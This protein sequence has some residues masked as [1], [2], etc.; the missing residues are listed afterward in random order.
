MT[1]HLKIRSGSAGRATTAGRSTIL[2]LLALLLLL[3][4]CRRGFYRQQADREVNCIVDHKTQLVGVA[5]GK[6][7][8]NIDPRSRMFDPNDPDCEPMPPDDPVSHQVM[9]CVDCKRGSKCW[10]CLPKTPFVEN[11]GWLEHLPFDE[12]GQLVLDLPGA[13]ELAR[14]ESPRY[15]S[16]LEELYLS[17]LDVTFERFRFDAQ[18]FGGAEVFMTADGRDRSGTGESSSLFEVSAARPGNNLRIEKL[19]ATGGELAAGFANSLVWQFAGT[20]DY[21]STTLLDFSLVQPLLRAGGRT[22]VLERLTISERAL[23]ANVRQMERFRRG[24]YLSV[25]TGRDPGE[26][27]SRRGGVFGGSGLEGFSGVGGGGFGRVANG[28]GG[29]F[30]QFAGGITGGAG[31]AGA[32]GY[33]GLLQT[34]QVLRN[35]HANVTAL[36]NSVEQLQASNEA[37]RIDRFQVDLAR[38]ALYNAQSQLLTAETQYQDTV[39]NFT[40]NLG[41]PPELNVKVSDSMLDRLNLLDP[42]LDALQRQVTDVLFEMR[43][44]RDDLADARQAE[45]GIEQPLIVPNLPAVPAESAAEMATATT[46]LLQEAERIKLASQQRFAAVKA[47]YAELEQALPDRRKFLRR[48]SRREELQDVNIAPE[49][50]SVQRLDERI[51]KLRSNLLDL[52]SQLVT[53]WTSIDQL[54]ALAGT[55]DGNTLSTLI[56]TL[57]A[58]SGQLLE[59]TLAQ[60]SA[61]LETVTF[62]PTELKPQQALAIASNYRPDWKNARA[63]LVD[64]W[65]LIYFN[66]NDLLSDVDIVFSGDIGNVDDNPFSLKG[67]NGRLRL[68]LEVDAPL[69]R[70]AERNV[71][72]QSLIEYQQAR[73]NYYQ[74]RDRLYQGLRNTLRQIRL[75]EINFELRRAAVQVAI[76]QVDLTQLRLL[77]PPRPGETSQFGNTTARDLVQ[78]LSDLLNVQ[79]DFLSVWVNYQVQRLNLEYDLGVMELAPNGMPLENNI[80]LETYLLDL[81]CNSFDL[82][83]DTQAIKRIPPIDPSYPEQIQPLPI[84]PD[85]KSITPEPIPSPSNSLPEEGAS[86]ELMYPTQVVLASFNV[87]NRADQPRAPSGHKTADRPVFPMALPQGITEPTRLPRPVTPAKHIYNGIVPKGANTEEQKSISIR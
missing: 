41:L 57:S 30:Q 44:L 6:Y 71:Y 76:S 42:E 64:A 40:I 55:P 78:S 65:R 82:G 85:P 54:V 9:L 66:A 58:L 63:S 28:D 14:L 47:D 3:P 32:G 38:Q 80:P 60:A 83:A 69:T 51:E 7:R 13:V 59:L 27:P 62:S 31:A 49:L 68:G 87:L 61:R 81:P 23:I 22:R 4:G 84:V 24:F 19:T 15:Q 25:I 73:R 11:P 12:Q 46:R 35:Q 70:L 20:D 21:S 2:L 5:P 10:R 86:S 26:G 52:E 77:E 34:Q 74:F 1:S 48:L 37:G 39:E 43:Q 53:S 50:F 29:R 45:A 8:I 16:E 56:S 72:R 79:N 36:S 67:T 17:A 75:N 18:F 33:Y